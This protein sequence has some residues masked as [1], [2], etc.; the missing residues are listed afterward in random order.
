MSGQESVDG[1]A[2]VADSLAVDDPHFEDVLF[3]AGSQVVQ[4]DRFHVARPESVEI[5]DAID[6]EFNRVRGARI[7]VLV[8]WHPV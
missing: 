4:H 3:L 6:R 7:D 2:E 8:A 1:T 5:Q